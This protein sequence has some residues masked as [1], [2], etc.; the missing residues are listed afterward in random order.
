VY[1]N[2]IYF[3]ADYAIKTSDK[4]TITPRFNYKSQQPW[5]FVANDVGIYNPKN[6]RLTG[7][8]TADWNASKKFGFVFGAEYYQDNSKIM[9]NDFDYIF[10]NGDTE[11]SFTDLA[12]FADATYN[13]KFAN[14]TAG[15][16]Y[17]DHSAVDAAFV[18]RIGLTKVIKDWHFKL[19]YSEAFKTPVI[20]NITMTPNIK[21][22]RISVAEFETGYRLNENMVLSANVFYTRIEDVIVYSEEIVDGDLTYDYVNYPHTGTAGLEIDYKYKGKW[23][24]VNASYSMYKASKDSQVEAYTIEGND[25]LFL[26]LPGQK[27]S[28]NAHLKLAKNL[29]LN[30][31]L[32]YFSAKYYYDYD[33]DWNRTLQKLDNTI[34]GHIHLSYENLL[35]EGLS[36]GIGLYN[37]GNSEDMFAQ[38]Y[39]GGGLPVLA[40]S[41][42][43]TFNLSYKF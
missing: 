14:I 43:L 15:V 30:P 13:S 42:E 24:Y 39:D 17:D 6:S 40:P 34:V 36:T 2:G 37:I 35:T 5:T 3:G 27:F 10:A 28:A 12:L 11:V 19:L 7:N 4:L 32:L 25:D 41:R 33:A 8:V 1:F 21:P 22:E 31:T 16:R 38:P 26:G 29:Y 9:E 20:E 23:G 18:P